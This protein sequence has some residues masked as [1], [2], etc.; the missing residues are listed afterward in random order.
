MKKNKS[1][2]EAEKC[3]NVSNGVHQYGYNY[4]TPRGDW[5]VCSACGKRK[6]EPI[7]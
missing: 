4:S 7:K 3:P 2:S 5:Y 1:I 6:L